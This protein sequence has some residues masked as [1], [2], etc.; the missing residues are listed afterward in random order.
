MDANSKDIIE[1]LNFIKDRM[2]TKD[3]LK[4][5][6]VGLEG[7]LNKKID[8]LATRI[9]GL[10]TRIDG[11]EVKLETKMDDLNTTFNGLNNRIDYELDKR[12]VLEVRVTRIEETIAS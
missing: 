5:E 12:K 2:V 3:D 6:L 7:K 8:G 11:L 4:D 9:D 10:E 1:T